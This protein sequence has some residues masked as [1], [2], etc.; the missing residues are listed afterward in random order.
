[1]SRGFVRE[2]DQ[3]EIPIIPPRAP[4][5]AGATNYVTA[6]GWQQLQKEL[7]ELEAEKQS[8]SADETDQR[9]ALTVVQVKL[10]QLNERIASAQVLTP[11]H[12][13]QDEVR[14][15]AR[16][17]LKPERSSKRQVFQIVGV[18]EADLKQQK[19]SFGAPIARMLMGKRVG[20]TAQLGT[21]REARRWIVEKI[22]YDQ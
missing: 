19:I 17:T 18:D 7:A 6:N 9:A 8:L 13:N 3:E 10:A 16:V 4:L 21:G 22:S 20:E 5:P 1:M 12:L 14:F 11:E 2:T 15:G